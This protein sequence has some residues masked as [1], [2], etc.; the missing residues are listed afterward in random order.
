[1]ADTGREL[2]EEAWSNGEGIR[3]DKE[4]HLER[5][6]AAV[7]AAGMA[8]KTGT[9]GSESEPKEVSGSRAARLSKEEETLTT[10]TSTEGRGETVSE[11]N[12]ADNGTRPTQASRPRTAVRRTEEEPLGAGS[13]APAA[14]RS[15]NGTTADWTVVSESDEGRRA[16]SMRRYQ[17]ATPTTSAMRAAEK[18]R[19]PLLIGIDRATE[20]LYRT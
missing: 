17:A 10:G 8:A 3:E 9:A 2:M 4:V 6:D 12:S 13:E 14:K 11:T 19:G 20:E 18:Y 5:R 7:E 15:K 1:M 16:D